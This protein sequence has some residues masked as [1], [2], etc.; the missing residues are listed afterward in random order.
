MAPLWKDER[1][2]ENSTSL[3]RKPTPRADKATIDERH[4]RCHETALPLIES[5]RNRTADSSADRS[6]RAQH[7]V[8]RRCNGLWVPCATVDDRR[9]LTRWRV[10]KATKQLCWRGHLARGSGES[11]LRFSLPG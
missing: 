11:D 5:V 7:G 10:G 9:S 1:W 4:R 3:A 8:P 6:D 2:R